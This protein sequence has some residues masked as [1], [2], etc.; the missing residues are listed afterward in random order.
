MQ[1]SVGLPSF[2]SESH[3][4][5]PDRLRRYARIADE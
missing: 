2:A 5:P 4:V 1:L 3:A